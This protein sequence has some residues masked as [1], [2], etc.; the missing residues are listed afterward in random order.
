MG[1]M[2]KLGGTAYFLGACFSMFSGWLSDRWIAS[3]ATPTLV[4]KTFTGGG[5]ALSG[6]FIGLAAVSE[7]NYCAVA[8]ILGVIFFGVASSNVWA[9]TQTLAGPEAAGRWTGFQNFIGNLAG[10]VAPAL[11]GLVLERTGE[12]YWAFVI[13]AG[14]AVVGMASWVFLLGP[15]EPVIWDR[16]LRAAAVPP[17]P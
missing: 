3:G 11:T 12:F 16:D 1:N 7:T 6:L 13:M 8:L 14:V 15:V 9:I 10:V 4:R 2:A 17:S 5:L